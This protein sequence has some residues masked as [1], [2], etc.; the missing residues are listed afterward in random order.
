M[1]PYQYLIWRTI[2]VIRGKWNGFILRGG[3]VW[4]NANDWPP[5]EIVAVTGQKPGRNG[6]GWPLPVPRYPASS[7]PAAV[8]PQGLFAQY[9]LIRECSARVLH[10]SF[11]L[12]PAICATPFA[13]NRSGAFHAS[14]DLSIPVSKR[15]ERL[16]NSAAAAERMHPG[17][18]CS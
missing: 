3:R 17:R 4:P 1:L 14:G 5:L 2:V 15:V 11:H 8:V 18:E 13:T 7:Q 12:A 10:I 6:I 9:L 16:C